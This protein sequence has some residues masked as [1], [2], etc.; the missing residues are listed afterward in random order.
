ME[1]MGNPGV[2]PLTGTSPGMRG[3]GHLLP[4]PLFVHPPSAQPESAR[5]PPN[6]VES[7]KWPPGA[8][9]PIQQGSENGPARRAGSFRRHGSG[10]DGAGQFPRS[11][12]EP[13][14]TAAAGR[15]FE[16]GASTRARIGAVNH[17][18]CKDTDASIEFP[19]LHEM[20][21]TK[22]IFPNTK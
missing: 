19:F 3:R 20:A 9:P 22:K 12:A 10:R 7:A 13:I 17:W 5:V 11:K 6:R 4:S 15:S 2:L 18:G 16:P 14:E 21:G 1:S 8:D